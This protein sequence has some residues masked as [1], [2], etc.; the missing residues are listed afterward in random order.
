MEEYQVPSGCVTSENDFT[1]TKAQLAAA[2]EA[3][4]LLAVCCETLQILHNSRGSS[5]DF[6]L[7]H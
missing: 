1:E 4:D 3:T 2:M 7:R 6:P 5:D